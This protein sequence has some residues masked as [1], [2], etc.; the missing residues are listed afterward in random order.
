MQL[1][2]VRLSVCVAGWL[3]GCL[4][5]SLVVCLPACLLCKGPSFL[6]SALAQKVKL[7]MHCLEILHN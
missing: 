1:L 6:S 7:S 5:V 3:V 4:S 2:P